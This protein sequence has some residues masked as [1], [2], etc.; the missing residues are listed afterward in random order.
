MY[1]FG[2]L[3]LDIEETFTYIVSLPNNK[4]A[5]C[6]RE[7]VHIINNNV[8]E[9]TVDNTYPINFI[10]TFNKLLLVGDDHKCTVY[11]IYTQKRLS[12]IEGNIPFSEQISFFP[13]GRIVCLL[14]DIT[15]K[16][17]DPITGDVLTQQAPPIVE[18]DIK[19]EDE[20][21]DDDYYHNDNFD[22]ER[23]HT[24]KDNQVIVCY[25]YQISRL[26]NIETGTFIQLGNNTLQD[27]GRIYNITTG[28]RN[29]IILKDD[30]TIIAIFHSCIEVWDPITG[31]IKNSSPY[32]QLTNCITISDHEIAFTSNN[33]QVIIFDTQTHKLIFNSK[34]FTCAF[35]IKDMMLWNNNHLLLV[36]NNKGLWLFDLKTSAARFLIQ[37]ENAFYK[38][39]ILSDNR[40]LIQFTDGS[41]KII[42]I[43]LHRFY[44][45]NILSDNRRLLIQFTD[46][47]VKNGT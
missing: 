23:L 6:T 47:N 19:T 41:A 29:I 17:V 22:I 8:I 7:H 33:S 35:D 45:I 43:W 27:D 31:E 5:A 39:N 37:L 34:L 25:R 13:D 11:D 12:E 18:E 24:Y 4:I 16:V 1:L 42:A 20:D 21:D 30:D 9:W 38:V 36:D 10:R 32:D 3:V 40:L 2:R 28:P 15:F 46:K 44:N 26:Y 14:N